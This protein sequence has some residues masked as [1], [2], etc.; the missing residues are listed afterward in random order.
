MPVIDALLDRVQFI[1]KKS[2]ANAHFVQQQRQHIDLLKQQ[3]ENKQNQ[4]EELKRSITNQ[5]EDIKAK[6]TTLKV[7]H[8]LQLTVTF[9]SYYIFQKH[10]NYR[11]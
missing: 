11:P 1:S 7:L 5:R 8:L 9:I 6:S 4:L 10:S 3:N 2:A